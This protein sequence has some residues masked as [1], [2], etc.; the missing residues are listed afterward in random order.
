MGDGMFDKVG[1]ALGELVDSIGTLD[2]TCKFKCENGNK[3]KPR[4]GHKPSSN[5][6]GS[7]GFQ[8]DTAELPMMTTCCDDHDR[9]YDTC[10]SNKERCDEVFSKCLKQMCDQMEYGFSAED[11]EG[12]KATT[13]LIH[14]GTEMLGCK[15]FRTAQET[16]CDCGPGNKLPPA[17]KP[18]K[19]PKKG[20]VTYTKKN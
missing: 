12:C 1:E 3:P 7:Y 20:T 14:T 18:P 10:N 5:G 4:V 2:K 15:A 13:E 8:F 17:T 9:C 16:A 6:C 11:Y 19:Q